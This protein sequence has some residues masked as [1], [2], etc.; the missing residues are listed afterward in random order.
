MARRRGFRGV[1][2]TGWHTTLDAFEARLDAQ[3]AAIASGDITAIEPFTEPETSNPLPR[4]LT[5]R[6]TELVWRCR[7]IEEQ[8]AA[9]LQR[10]QTSIDRLLDAPAPS[11]PAAEPVYFDSRV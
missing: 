8:L 6:A 11:A 7:R 10:S 2:H 9:A 3:A 5:E 1:S 4:E